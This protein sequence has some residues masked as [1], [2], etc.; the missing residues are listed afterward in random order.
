MDIYINNYHEEDRPLDPHQVQLNTTTRLTWHEPSEAGA[1]S[2]AWE[3][4]VP[5]K[6]L[7]TTSDNQAT[8]SDNQA[9]DKSIETDSGKTRG[10]WEE[11]QQGRIRQPV[12]CI[13]LVK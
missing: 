13:P 11:T 10:I 9:W 1:R 12:H 3:Y 5:G 7:A 2:V 4:K 6:D 8:T